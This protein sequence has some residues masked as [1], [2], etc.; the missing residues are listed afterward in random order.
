V[1]PIA[2]RSFAQSE[3]AL[4]ALGEVPAKAANGANAAAARKTRINLL[5]VYTP[6]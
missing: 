6:S 3:R 4:A 5:T 2:A 1:V